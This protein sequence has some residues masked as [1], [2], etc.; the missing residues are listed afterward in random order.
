MQS[1]DDALLL[2]A[3]GGDRRALERLL[4]RHQSQVFR[5][6]KKMCR[7]EEDAQDVLQETLLAAARTLPDFR[8]AS[9]IS[10]W[11]YT[12]ARSFCIKKRRT[13]KFAPAEVESLDQHAETAASLPDPGRTPEDHAASRQLRAALDEAIGALDPI[14]REVLVLRDVEGLPANEVAEVLGLSVEAVK[15]RLHRARVAVRER[16]A[17]ILA[18]ES[19][20]APAGPGCRDVVDLLSRRLE[21]EIDGTACAE[22]EEHLKGCA[23]CA[24]RCDS[25]RATLALCRRAG[26][27][28]VPPSVERSVRQALNSFLD[29]RR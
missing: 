23:H 1:D 2:A 26:E 3:Q 9:S 28:R 6:G 19:A 15:S 24:G 29:L 10:T 14:Y 4:T 16:L 22:L 27:A 11:L 8:G 12:I 7:S 5:F 18:K 13:S 25:L 20:G 21:G 17:P